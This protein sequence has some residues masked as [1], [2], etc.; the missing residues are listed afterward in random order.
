MKQ[1]RSVGALILSMVF[2]S[3]AWADSC[4]SLDTAIAKEKVLRGAMQRATGPIRM[5]FDIPTHRDVACA[6]SQAYRD[7]IISLASLVNA[8]C[9]SEDKQ[10]NFAAD[11][12]H[13]LKD[14]NANVGLLCE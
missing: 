11:L 14:A 3:A 1:P 12:N 4:S 13:K 6:A 2:V 10:T 8:R 7:Q 5:S 9:V